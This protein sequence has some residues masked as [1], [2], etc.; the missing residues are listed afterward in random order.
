MDGHDQAR[1][2]DAAYREG[3]GRVE[4]E[5]RVAE[6]ERRRERDAA[7]VDDRQIDGALAAD[8]LQAVTQLGKEDGVARDPD[9]GSVVDVEYEADHFVCLRR[10]A[11]SVAGDGRGDGD[12]ADACS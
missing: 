2:E 6:A 5:A 11:G 1:V 9:A 8:R 3:F 7:G 10:V 12:L 4:G